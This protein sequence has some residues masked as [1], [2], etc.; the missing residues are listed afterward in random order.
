MRLQW[1]EFK[2]KK[3][4]KQIEW[5]EPKLRSIEDIKFEN[6]NLKSENKVLKQR[7][8]TAKEI[9]KQLQDEISFLREQHRINF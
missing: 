1:F 4:N 5:V 9:I 6:E 8:E 2:D 3:G 7:I